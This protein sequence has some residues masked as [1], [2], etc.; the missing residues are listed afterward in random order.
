MSYGSK[1]HTWNGKAPDAWSTCSNSDFKNW[2]KTEGHQCLN[3]NAPGAPD[4]P[5]T[6]L[7]TAA[8]TTFPQTAPPGAPSPALLSQFGS[9]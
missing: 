4:A 3:A 1:E 2:F 6:G 9:V 8:P 5:P 7:P